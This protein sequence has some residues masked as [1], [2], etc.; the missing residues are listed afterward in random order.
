MNNY[1]STQWTPLSSSWVYSDGYPID[2]H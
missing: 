1:H 2:L